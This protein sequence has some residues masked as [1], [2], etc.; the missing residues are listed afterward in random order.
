MNNHQLECWSCFRKTTYGK[1]QD[2][3]GRC[4]NCGVKIE[5]GEY[6]DLL[7][8]E[9]YALLEEMVRLKAEFLKE[10]DTLS[11]RNYELRKAFQ[12]AF[13]GLNPEIPQT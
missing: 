2:L 3:D 8:E 12:A 13:N 9:H 4:P 11:N 1:V 6:Y 5:L 7:L 10:L